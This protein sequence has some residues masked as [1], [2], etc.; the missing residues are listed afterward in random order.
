MQ[1]SD[2]RTVKN[3]VD[4]TREGVYTRKFLLGNVIQFTNPAGLNMLKFVV[5]Y[6]KCHLQRVTIIEIIVY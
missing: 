6:C 2:Y 1:Y 5:Y 3:E 4:L